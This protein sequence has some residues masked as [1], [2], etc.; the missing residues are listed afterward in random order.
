MSRRDKNL[1]YAVVVQREERILGKDEVGISKLPDSATGCEIVLMPIRAGNLIDCIISVGVQRINGRTY[2]VLVLVVSI[3][4]FQADGV[5]SS[6]IYP[7]IS[8]AALTGA[9]MMS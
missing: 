1:L 6:P 7:S 5:G 9:L 2:G 3:S 4:A 8:R